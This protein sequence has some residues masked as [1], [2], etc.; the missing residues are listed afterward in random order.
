MSTAGD[1]MTAVRVGAQ[2][3]PAVVEWIGDLLRGGASE[4]EAAEMVRRDIQSRRAAYQ[5]ARDADMD[6]LDEK[7]ADQP[8][9]GGE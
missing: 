5:A 9:A 4:G 2:V 3:L 6:A 8:P 7:W 1:I